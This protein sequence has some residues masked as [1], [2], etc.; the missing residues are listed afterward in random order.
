MTRNRTLRLTAEDLVRF[1][2]DALPIEPK[3]DGIFLGDGL[4]LLS[5]VRDVDIIFADPPYNKGKDFGNNRDHRRDYAE[6]TDRW[7]G[8]AARALRP[9]GTLYVCACWEIGGVIQSALQRHLNVR[10]R[11]TWKRDK[12]RGAK[13]NWKNNMED[14]WFAT[15][16]DDYTFHLEAVKVRKPVIAPYRHPDG[17]PKDWV[18]TAGGRVRMTHPSN[19]WTDLCVPFWSMPE[20]TPHPTQKPERLVERLLLASSSP[21]QLLV[22]P[23]IGSGTSAVVARRMG[24]RYLGCDLNP[25][26]VRLALKRLAREARV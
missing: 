5:R 6:W 7:I 24:R 10:N 8:L 12:G 26:Y 1:Q 16:G 13:R 4:D 20:N 17:R 19:I 25:E 22:D 14:V 18:E 3:P 11:I 15:Q 23:F 2:P 9:G 21:G